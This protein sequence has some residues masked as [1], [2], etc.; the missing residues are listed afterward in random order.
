MVAP[1]ALDAAG[2]MG[3]AL[4]RCLERH[5]DFGLDHEARNP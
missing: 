4:V 1:E 5:T 3:V 2:L